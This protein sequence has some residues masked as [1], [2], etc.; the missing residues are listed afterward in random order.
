MYLIIFCKKIILN[1]NE[2]TAKAIPTI[3]SK[4]I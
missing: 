3:T 1:F 2:P 4:S